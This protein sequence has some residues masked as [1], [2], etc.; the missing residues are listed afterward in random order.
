MDEWLAM[1]ISAIALVISFLSW[2]TASRANVAST[3]DR[4]FEIYAD[5]EAFVTAWMRLGHPDMTLL[6]KLAGAW[7]RSHFLCRE[8][9]TAFIRKLWLDG[10]EADLMDR[11]AKGIVPGDEQ[12]AIEKSLQLF[13][14]H[15]NFDKLREVMVPDLR[16]ASGSGWRKPRW[17]GKKADG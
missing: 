5:V 9:V 3:F 10:V 16:V 15:T 14:E 4:R 1:A 6:P 11:T 7:T 12:R 13:N 8:E 2:Q 17:P